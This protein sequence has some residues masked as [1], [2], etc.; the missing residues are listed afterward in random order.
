MFLPC[1]FYFLQLVE[2]EY[3]I[4]FND[5]RIDCLK[6]VGVIIVPPLWFLFAKNPITEIR[7]GDILILQAIISPNRYPAIHLYGDQL[8]YLFKDIFG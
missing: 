7:Y 8:R 2:L 6:V 3:T 5:N 1:L 4:C